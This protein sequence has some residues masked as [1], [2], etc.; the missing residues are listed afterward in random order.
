MSE[1]GNAAARDS[2][3][4][5]YM[6][7]FF[8][9]AVL[10]A[11]IAM[12][13]I[14]SYFLSAMTLC[15]NAEDDLFH[16]GTVIT[17]TCPVARDLGQDLTFKAYFVGP[18]GIAA[19]ET[20]RLPAHLVIKDPDGSIMYDMNFDDKTIISFR[21]E[22]YGTYTATITSLQTEKHPTFKDNTFIQYS[23]GFLTDHPDVANP[24]GNALNVMYP[25]GYTVITFGIIFS[26]ISFIKAATGRQNS[27]VH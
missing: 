17:V 14:S 23:F 16:P 13:A 5:K 8:A 22:I 11:G 9:I 19:G 6:V 20:I 15:K 12:V 2:I 7:L 3:I 26:I 27:L 4:R 24:F 10:S 21:P 18:V 1:L 25:I